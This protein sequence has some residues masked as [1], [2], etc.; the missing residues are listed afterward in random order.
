MLSRLF[1]RNYAIIEE[2]D[3]CFS[4]GLNTITGETGA[5][6]SIIV[7]ALGLILG[8]RAEKKTLYDP[9][10]KCIVEG[11]FQLRDPELKVFFEK[12]DLDYAD[13]TIIRREI[14]AEGKSRAFINDTPVT[15]PVLK[16]LSKRLV[17]VHSQHGSILLNTSRFQLLIIDGFAGH[18][19]LLQLFRGKYTRYKQKEKQLAELKEKSSRAQTEADYLQFQFDELEQADLNDTEQ[20]KLEQ[21]LHQLTH[22][23][24]IKR[25]LGNIAYLLDE[26]EAAAISQLKEASRLLQP[27]EQYHAGMEELGSRLNSCL[28]ELRDL[29]GEISSLADKTFLDPGRQQEI[30]DRLDQLYRLQ[31][32]HHLNSV[33][34][35]IE[36]KN[37]FQEQLNNISDLDDEIAA[38]KAQLKDEQKELTALAGELSAGRAGVVPRVEKEITALLK[39][40]GMPQAV[41]RIKQERTA[42]A[43]FHENGIDHIGFYFSANKGFQPVLLSEVASGGELSRLMLCIKGLTAKYTALP[44]IVF[45]EIDTGISG[46]VALRTAKLMQE[47]SGNLQVLAIT[48]LPQIASKGGT[49]FFV[50]KEQKSGKTHTRMK[51]LEYQERILEIAKMLSGDRPSESAMTNAEELLQS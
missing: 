27:L 46:E 22:A 24:E 35:L 29:S 41:F 23:E 3:I 19:D 18:T 8:E 45:D 49:H 33:Q 39:E 25:S 38:L 50:Y 6:K 42:P 31:Q 11:Y 32:K 21:E 4:G 1:I 44:T 10:R 28:I 43:D 7:G 9:G 20:E 12:S 36:L 37:K 47:F 51:K 40:T 30:Q 26:H 16:E 5:G 17:D 13:E 15:L 34:E 48:H 2:L 14:T